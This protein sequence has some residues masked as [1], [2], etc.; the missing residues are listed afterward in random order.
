MQN[1]DWKS[2]AVAY[3]LANSCPPA[4]IIEQAFRHA[5]GLVVDGISADIVA[6]RKSL[7]KEQA[8]SG[9]NGETKIIQP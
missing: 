7:A 6:A 8:A 2:E 1:I 5:A 9:S 3:T 4:C